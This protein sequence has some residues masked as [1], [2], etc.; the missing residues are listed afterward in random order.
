MTVEFS[1][2]KPGEHYE[3]RPGGFTVMFIAAHPD[4]GAYLIVENVDDAEGNP[5][6][7]FACVREELE[8]ILG[9]PVL[10]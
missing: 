6:K 4:D 10:P 9:T 8:L 3:Y 5:Q 2:L 7:F 1:D